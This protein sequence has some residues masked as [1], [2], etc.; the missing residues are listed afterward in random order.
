MSFTMSEGP[1]DPEREKKE[2]WIA[3]LQRRIHA[4]ERERRQVNVLLIVAVVFGMVGL[5]FSK[6]VALIAFAALAILWM[7]GHYLANV[8]IW[9]YRGKIGEVQADL[10]ML[11]RA[12]ANGAGPLCAPASRPD[13]E[14]DT[15]RAQFDPVRLPRQAVLSLPWQRR[16]RRST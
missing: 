4:L 15:V 7:S 16:S 1:S 11:E 13:L 5:F 2:E 3:E 6:V 8:Y 9:D 12:R 14:S 10:E